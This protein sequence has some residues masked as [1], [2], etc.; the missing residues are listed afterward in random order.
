MNAKNVHDTLTRASY[1]SQIA[2]NV[3]APN[4]DVS[5]LSVCVDVYPK[6]MKSFDWEV[7]L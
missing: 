1:F 2:N 4:D 5:V 6:D 3:I 7:E